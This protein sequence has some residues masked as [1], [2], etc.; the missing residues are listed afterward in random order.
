MNPI[1]WALALDAALVDL[2]ALPDPSASGDCGVQLMTIH[3]SKGLEFEV[4]IVPDLQAGPG[5]GKPGMLSWLERGIPPEA[6][7]SEPDD[8]LEITEFL[9]APFSPKGSDPGQAKKWVDRQRGE[10]ERQEARRLLYVAAT[11]ARDEL[12]FFAR[13]SDKVVNGAPSELVEPRE[14][15]LRTA[16]PAWLPEIQRRFDEFR[17]RAV[18]VAEPFTIESLAAGEAGKYARIPVDC[19]QAH[20]APPSS[21]RHWRIIARALHI[22]WQRAAPRRGPPLYER[23]EGGLL[24][25]ALGKAV[26]ALF[27]QFAQLLATQPQDAALAS[28]A[29]QQPR[30]AATIRAAGVEPATAA[31]IAAQALRIV[32]QAAADPL[33]QWILA[34]HPDAA[35][36]VRWTGVVAGALR[37]VQVDRVFR[38]GPAPNTPALTVDPGTWWII[39]YK[40]AHED[41]LDPAAALPQLRR[42]FAPQIEAYANV[43]RNLRGADAKICG[44]LYYPRMSALDWW[45]L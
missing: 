33:A 43:L 13:P 29:R 24:S 30:I 35:T 39:D 6:G 14:S 19:G 20:Y 5:R 42:L 18:S 1:C 9:V 11:R 34:P 25:R 15:L 8:S 4:V 7:A 32:G 21:A 40:T 38:A 45:E 2:P 31:R 16:W 41:G 36:E 23:H 28:L 26:H 10:R 22:R 17:A 12:H 27:Q 3:K 37:T 44:A